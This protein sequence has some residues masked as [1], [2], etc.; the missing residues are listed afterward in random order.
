[1]IY[2]YYKELLYRYK[3]IYKK[4]TNKKNIGEQKLPLSLYSKS[5]QLLQ[6]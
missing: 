1:M 6:K 4:I 5:N 2:L 3:N